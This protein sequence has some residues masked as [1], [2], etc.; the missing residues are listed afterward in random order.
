MSFLPLPKK[1]AVKNVLSRKIIGILFG[2]GVKK[3]YLCSRK[4]RRRMSVHDVLC[5]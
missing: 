1:S 2:E 3:H 4:L 5:G